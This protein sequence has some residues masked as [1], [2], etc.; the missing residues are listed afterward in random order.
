VTDQVVEVGVLR[1]LVFHVGLPYRSAAA[2]VAASARKPFNDEA[3]KKLMR[4]VRSDSQANHGPDV[5]TMPLPRHQSG[6]FPSGGLDMAR[7]MS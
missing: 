5:G 7:T 2:S 6:F 4:F 3:A 1:A